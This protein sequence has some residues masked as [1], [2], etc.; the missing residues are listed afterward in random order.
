MAEVALG[1]VPAVSRIGVPVDGAATPHLES[2]VTLFVEILAVL[3]LDGGWIPRSVGDCRDECQK[4]AERQKHKSSAAR[5]TFHAL[6]PSRLIRENTAGAPPC[7]GA[8]TPCQP[9]LSS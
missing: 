9:R 7:N 2:R 4:G 6:C 3:I 1:V 5:K 8:P